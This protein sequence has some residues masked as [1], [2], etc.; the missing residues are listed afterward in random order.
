MKIPTKA[1]TEEVRVK[2]SVFPDAAAD[3]I[4]EMPVPKIISK[5]DDRWVLSF[6]I[7][8][9]SSTSNKELVLIFIEKNK[10]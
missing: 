6:Y 2:R 10:D 8:S 4:A 7:Y 3:A 9:N 1:A 5:S